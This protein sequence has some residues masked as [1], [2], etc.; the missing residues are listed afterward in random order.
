MPDAV[1]QPLLDWFTTEEGSRYRDATL[2]GAG[3]ESA[4]RQ[5]LLA[6]QTS[7]AAVLSKLIAGGARFLFGSDSPATASYGNLPGLNGR[8]EMDHWLAAGVTLRTLLQSLTIDNAR[9]FGLDREIGTVEAGKRAHLLLL[10]ANPLVSVAA[11]DQMEFVIHA[12]R[13]LARATLS[14]RSRARSIAGR[15]PS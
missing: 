2:S 3:G 1:P 14:A 8:L 15:G 5:R 13:P 10:G 9:A 11:Y 7:Y 6:R 4:F 12:G